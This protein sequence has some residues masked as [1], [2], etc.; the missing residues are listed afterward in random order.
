MASAI[1]QSGMFHSL[2]SN[3]TQGMYMGHRPEAYESKVPH[4]RSG[5]FDLAQ[6]EMSRLPVIYITFEIPFLIDS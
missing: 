3:S 2:P 6:D 1:P 4:L 5:S